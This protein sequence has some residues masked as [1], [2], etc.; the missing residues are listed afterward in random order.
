MSYAFKQRIDIRQKGDCSLRVKYVT[1][2]HHYVGSNPAG[3]NLRNINGHRLM[4]DRSSSTRCVSI[5]FR[6]AV[7]QLYLKLMCICT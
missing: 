5:R 2:N 1:F 3:L 6:L 7:L 4:V